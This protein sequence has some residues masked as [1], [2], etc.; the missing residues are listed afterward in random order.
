[1]K[2]I[3]K[4]NLLIKD[5]LKLERHL[6]MNKINSLLIK[7]KFKIF[8]QILTNNSKQIRIFIDNNKIRIM[9]KMII[10]MT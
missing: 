6:I 4:I 8:I 5:L 1:M 3:N 10:I 9:K 7:I 2:M